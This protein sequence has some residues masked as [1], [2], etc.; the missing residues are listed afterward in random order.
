VGDAA[1]A[2]AAAIERGA[3]GAYNVADDEPAPVIAWLPELARTLG[4]KPPRRVPVWLG[5]LATGEVGVLMMTRIRGAS[6]AKAR[7]EL[8]W[9][10]RYATWREGFR[11]GLADE[12]VPL[13][14]QR[15]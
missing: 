4:A 3:P 2:T 12:A 5:R 7:R 10:P 1:A 9:E 15:T 6:N 13:T 11:R 8:G 14:R